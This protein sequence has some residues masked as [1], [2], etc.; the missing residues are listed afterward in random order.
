MSWRLLTGYQ[1]CRLRLFRKPQP[2]LKIRPSSVC[3]TYGTDHQSN[4]EN[5]R[6]VETLRA[7]S[8]D[9]GKIRRLKG[10]VLLE[11]ETYAEEIAN[12]LKELGA[13]QT[14]IASI[15]ERCPEAIVCSPAA[16]NTKRKLWQMVC[17][18]KT[19]LI[20][21]I[22]QFPE[23]FFAVKDQ[24][25]QKLNVQFFQELGLKNVVITRFL[26]TASSIF[27]NPVENNKQMIGVLLESYL[28]LGGSE[29]NA[30]VWLL[31]LLSQNPFIVLSSPTAVG[32]VLKFLQGQGFTDSEVLQL[33]SKL[34]GFLFQ[35]QP[36]SIQNSISFTKTTFECTDHDLRQLVVKCPAL[37]YYPAPVLEER[38]Q[39]LLK[40]GISVAQIRASPM[41]LEL[42]PQIIQYRIRKLN[43]LGYGI[44]DGHLASLNGTKKEFEANFSK[45]QAK[46]GRPLFNPVASLKVEE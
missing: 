19:E 15:L 41:V 13:N 40:E 37:L 30:K 7:C 14:V 3:V 20:Q 9:I 36:E 43:S 21:L 39:A 38:I 42:T 35:L 18:T 33:L 17:K 11:E 26:T 29:A 6:T 34:K 25:N 23:S 44:K 5:K 2:A 4:K 28:N 8:V 46:Q 32:E 1:L 12:I 10:W 45:M 24:E 27:H 16:V 22:E 31:K